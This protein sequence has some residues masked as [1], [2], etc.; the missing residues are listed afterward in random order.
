MS[1]PTLLAA[2]CGAM[3]VGGLALLVV[4]VVGYDHDSRIWIVG[5][6]VVFGRAL[7]KASAGVQDRV[8][9]ATAVADEAF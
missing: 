5:A 4:A 6:A 1:G 7:R 8:A 9:E 3:V 2:A